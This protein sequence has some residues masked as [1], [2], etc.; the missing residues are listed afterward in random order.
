MIGQ[1]VRTTAASRRVTIAIA[2]LATYVGLSAP[3]CATFDVLS[4]TTADVNA[5]GTFGNALAIENNTALIGAPYAS[6]PSGAAFVFDMSTGTQRY[7]FTPGYSDT[8]AEFGTSVAIAGNSAVIGA[9]YTLFG[10][11]WSG[12]V[13]V[14]D[15]ST[16]Q[17]R[18]RLTADNPTELAKFGAAVATSGNFA[19]VGAPGYNSSQ[20]AAYLFDLTTGQQIWRSYIPELGS[21]SQ[22]GT[23]VD[24]E[25]GVAV[26]GASGSEYGHNSNLGTVLVVDTNKPDWRFT[27]LNAG[28]GTDGDFFGA[29]VA[30]SNNRVIVGA[31]YAG[32]SGTYGVGAAYVYDAT[33]GEQ[34]FRLSPPRLESRVLFGSTVAIDGDL[35]LVGAPGQVTASG[36]VGAAYLYDLAK[37]ELIAEFIHPNPI[38]YIPLFQADSFASRVALSGGSVL[39]TGSIHETTYST[40][41]AVFYSGGVPEPTA[42]SLLASASL[43]LALLRGRRRVNE[44]SRRGR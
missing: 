22:F 1:F 5:R 42:A 37:G 14:Y 2:F 15:L 24:I 19:L 13:S 9:P 35:A 25:D 21:Y 29:S 20:G 44:S 11:R 17:Q 16:G 39:L 26:I 7:K 36:G 41:S 32:T 10:Q 4:L 31:P 33:T 12:S 8:G 40:Y 3:A 28:D 34:L 27:W 43:G 18:F 23:S 6:Y 38:E 30:I